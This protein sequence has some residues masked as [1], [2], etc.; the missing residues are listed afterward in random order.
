MSLFG[1]LQ[2]SITDVKTGTMLESI[3]LRSNRH[4]SCALCGAPVQTGTH[5]NGGKYGLIIIMLC[6]ERD[7]AISTINPCFPP[8]EYVPVGAGA[9]EKRDQEAL[10][11]SA[12][13]SIDFRRFRVRYGSDEPSH[14]SSIRRKHGGSE[15]DRQRHTHRQCMSVLTHYPLGEV[16]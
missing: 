10:H 2:R 4:A 12:G 11:S 5:S 14:I 9:L 1:M 16:P 6:F 7:P 3:F 8:E 15:V 13:A